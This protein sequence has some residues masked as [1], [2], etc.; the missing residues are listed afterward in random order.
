MA[1]DRQE[2]LRHEFYVKIEGIALSPDAADRIARAV[3]KAALNELATLDV[4]LNVGV[5]FV[6][7]GTQGIELVAKA[8]PQ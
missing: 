4:P 8:G 3:R 2:K 1:S 7:N 6:G 5:R